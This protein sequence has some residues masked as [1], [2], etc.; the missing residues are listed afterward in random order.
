[1]WRSRLLATLRDPIPLDLRSTEGHRN[2]YLWVGQGDPTLNRH[3]GEPCALGRLIGEG[4]EARVYQLLRLRTGYWNEVVKICKFPVDHPKYKKWA[5]EVRDETNAFSK[6]PDV[7]R[8]PAWL[9]EV[10]GGVVKVQNYI[11]SGISQD[12]E[13]AY[14]IRPI[15]EAL[16]RGD[17][18]AADSLTEQMIARDGPHGLLLEQRAT[19]LGLRGDFEAARAAFD[20][21]VRA[22]R[23]EGSFNILVAYLNYA[24]TL[25]QLYDKHFDELPGLMKLTLDDGTVFSQQF[26]VIGSSEQLEMDRDYSDQALEVLLEALVVE[27]CF[28]PA[29]RVLHDLTPHHEP[30]M[31]LAVL[32]SLIQID[33]LHAGLWRQDFEEAQAA[34]ERKSDLPHSE[35][36][37]PPEVLEVL[38]QH[39]AAYEP[40]VPEGADQATSRAFAAEYYLS[41]GDLRRAEQAI[42]EAIELAPDEPRYHALA[43]EVL[44]LQ[45]RWSESYE[46]LQRLSRQFTDSSA[47]YDVLGRTC[48]QLELYRESCI[49]FHKAFSCREDNGALI[50]ARLGNA[51][52]RLGDFDRAQS[53]TRQALEISGNEPQTNYFALLVVR[54]ALARGVIQPDAALS[55]SADSLSRLEAAGVLRADHFV[56]GAQIAYLGKQRNL[57]IQRLETAQRLSP[58]NPMIRDFLTFVQGQGD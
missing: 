1:M 30:E 21:C 51:Y 36:P 15:V 45:D 44:N 6:L 7:E 55:E 8:E 31:R 56:A 4:D 54:D 20:Q 57:A 18:D 50:L 42:H 10:P 33:P 32:N 41:T 22:Y 5:T 2:R 35:S 3:Y 19:I 28:L 47:I 14:Q 38:Q 34:L 27:P 12:W 11:P 43:C 16:H 53:Y 49:A 46:R 39:E 58:K 37:L 25:M 48:D 52:R 9:V 40:P 24:N 29:L 23:S 17:L 26:A 13:S